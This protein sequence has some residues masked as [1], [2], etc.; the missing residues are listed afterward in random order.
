MSP[1]SAADPG[2]EALDL[3]PLYARAFVSGP[4][5]EANTLIDEARRSLNP[6][7]RDLAFSWEV[8]VPETVPRDWFETRLVGRLVY[9]CESSRAP[10]PEC[11]GV[12]VSLFVGDTLFCVAAAE[13]VAFATEVLE[14]EN[15]DLVERFGTGESRQPIQLPGGEG[16]A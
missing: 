2:G 16:S 4:A 3:A 11:Q 6:G 12:F 13:V 1:P 10:L 14:L 8:V 5:V 7:N 9:H 15:E